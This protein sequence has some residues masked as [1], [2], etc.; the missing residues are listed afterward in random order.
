MASMLALRAVAGRASLQAEQAGGSLLQ[1]AVPISWSCS[2]SSRKFSSAVQATTSSP[3]ASSS[4]QQAE[5]QGSPRW[6]E[7]EL[8]RIALRTRQQSRTGYSETIT[9]WAVPDAKSGSAKEVQS[10]QRLKVPLP[11]KPATSSSNQTEDGTASAAGAAPDT[12]TAIAGPGLKLDGEALRVFDKI[13]GVLTKDGKKAVAQ[14]RALGSLAWGRH[15]HGGPAC[16]SC[17]RMACIPVLW[18][19]ASSYSWPET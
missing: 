12:A 17:V 14:V 1:G 5:R 8:A 16:L 15:E 7:A 19:S 10:L 13:V 18:H 3:S 4:G 11:L 9:S 6:D 2:C